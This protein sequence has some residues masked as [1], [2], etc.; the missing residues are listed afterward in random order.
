MAEEKKL[1]ELEAKLG[2]ALASI[3][4]LKAKNEELI[5][6]KRSTKTGAEAKLADAEAKIEE[7]SEALDK[8]RKDS[9]KAAKKYEA[10][11]KAATDSQT[12]TRERLHKLMRDD[13]LR[14]E[15]V[16][17]NVKKEYLEAAHALL[18]DSIQIDDEKG[19]AFALVKGTDGKESRVSIADYAKSWAASEAGKNF[20]GAAPS[21]GG[22][23]PG[24]GG[25]N[26]PG[27]TMSRA[28][29]E[30]LDSTA[31]LEFSKGGGTL[32]E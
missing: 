1:E 5:A 9:E 7:L 30:A 16:A 27:K 13:G 14:K 18:R 15:L 4:R 20:V 11:L 17:Q 19:E 10:D 25:S 32:T 22:G 29:F 28:Q 6:E 31:K 3:D 8:T 12:S 26:P 21:S 2:E 23:A 24:P